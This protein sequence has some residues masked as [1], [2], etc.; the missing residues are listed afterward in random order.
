MLISDVVE[1]VL[2]FGGFLCLVLLFM[3][4]IDALRR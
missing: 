1:Y 2:Y 3:V 4:I